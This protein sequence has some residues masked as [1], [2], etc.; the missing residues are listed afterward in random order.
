MDHHCPFTDT[1]IGWGNY[2]YYLCLLFWGSCSMSSFLFI[3]FPKCRSM[4][5]DKDS[6]WS[7]YFIILYFFIVIA[8]ILLVSLLSQHVFFSALDKTTIE[9]KETAHLG[10]FFSYWGTPKQS[11]FNFQR[12]WGKNILLWLI[13]TRRSIE[14]D[15]INFGKP[16][17]VKNPK[18][19]R[20][21][22]PID[23]IPIE[24]LQPLSN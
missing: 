17:F 4:L 3:F 11:F 18:I 15:G 14:G 2:K 21:N 8:D 23:P 9:W 22:I 12:S 16:L 20:S 19:S 7:W 6:S 24:N 5:F 13:P 1:C 10:I